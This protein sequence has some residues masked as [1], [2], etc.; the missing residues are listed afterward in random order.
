MAKTTVYVLVTLSI[1]K[2]G[3]VIRKNVGVSFCLYE[4][5]AHQGLDISNEYETHMVDA[6]WRDDA[7]VSETVLAMRDTMELVRADIAESLR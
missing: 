7:G 5:E 1:G 6:D 3:E 2:T 4:A